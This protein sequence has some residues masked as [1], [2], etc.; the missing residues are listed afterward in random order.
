MLMIGIKV[1]MMVVAMV[2]IDDDMWT[3]LG[4]PLKSTIPRSSNFVTACP[5]CGL[6]KNT[7]IGVFADGCSALMLRWAEAGRMLTGELLGHQVK[8]RLPEI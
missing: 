4:M 8:V 6:F 7:I 1:M 5:I 3:Y 2:A